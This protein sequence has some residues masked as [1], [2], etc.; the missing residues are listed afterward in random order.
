MPGAGAPAP[1]T[2]RHGPEFAAQF[3]AA[4]L[5]ARGDEQEEGGA[6]AGLALEPGAAAVVLDDRLHDRQ[7][8]AGARDRGGVGRV[9]PVERL[10]QLRL[11]LFRD[12]DA[13]VL[14]L[15]A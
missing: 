13:V 12:A 15:D 8:E 11:V 7:A 6:A 14:D 4:D 5:L 3:A 2:S 10:E 9:D 1:R